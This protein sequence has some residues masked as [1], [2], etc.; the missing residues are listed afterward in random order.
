MRTNAN[1]HVVR[2][3]HR[4]IDMGSLANY[5]GVHMT[6]VG[7]INKDKL[8]PTPRHRQSLF[9]YVV[10]HIYYQA[11]YYRLTPTPFA[12]MG[13]WHDFNAAVAVPDAM[14]RTGRRHK[15][16]KKTN[17]TRACPQT[18]AHAPPHRAMRLLVID[19]ETGSG[20]VSPTWTVPSAWTCCG[21]GT[22]SL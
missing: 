6:T 5:T 7:W 11:T 4:H 9:P 17:T 14:T 2:V 18:H 1:I 3:R 19:I 20:T 21:N 15:Q 8:I 16:N 10:S 12:D 13:L 22:S